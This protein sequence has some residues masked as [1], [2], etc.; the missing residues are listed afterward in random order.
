MA[1][2]RTWTD[3]Q[4]HTAVAAS[5]SMKEVVERLR[6][7][8][9]AAGYRAA[10]IRVEVLDLDTSHFGRP[11]D[12]RAI[13][14][15]DKARRQPPSRRWSDDDLAAAVRQARSLKGVFDVLELTV[16][17]TQWHVLRATIQERGLDTS[18]WQRPVEGPA[19]PDPWSD[20]DLRRLVPSCRSYAELMRRLGLPP[21]GRRQTRIRDRVRQLGIDTSH[22]K[23][24]GWARGVTNPSGTT[25]RPLDEILVRGD[26]PVTT[27]HLK[28]RLIDEGVFRAKCSGCG[29]E[30]WLGG[31]IPLE[32]DHI[33]GDRLDNRRENLRLLCPNCHALTDT[34]RGRNIGRYHPLS[35]GDG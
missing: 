3:D 18:H 1:R 17:G 23:G 16:G 8:A 34:Y 35:P 4:L 15:G 22:M 33:N 5:T 32:L 24:Q 7:A 31:P 12:L 19:R 29:L 30:E 13:G 6:A 11:A 21:T 10:R 26:R 2:R 28:R 9:G 27:S 14:N 20:D 25:A